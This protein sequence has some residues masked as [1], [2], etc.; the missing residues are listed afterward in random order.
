MIIKSIKDVDDKLIRDFS[1]GVN[2]LDSFFV[3]HAFLND[4]IGY[5][6][7]FVALEKNNVVGFF[8]LSSAQIEFE[9]M[10]K[11]LNYSL[12][13]YPIPAI[14]IAR[15]AVSKK[16][17]GKGFGKA[18]LKEA[19]AKIVYASINVGVRIVLVDAKETSKTF[20]E[21]FGFQLLKEDSL[22]YFISMSTV[23]DAI[24][25]P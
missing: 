3:K 2:S 20:Y 14:R 11:D 24:M 13:R 21:Q 10:P 4:Q 22:T 25:N 1:C 23:L 19:F 12:P 18:L 17:Q 16:Y 9:S 6:K 8:T 7:T 5:G 15:L